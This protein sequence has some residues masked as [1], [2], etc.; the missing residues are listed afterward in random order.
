MSC[1][2][3][4]QRMTSAGRV[5][6]RKR[7][8]RA[9][10][11]WLAVFLVFMLL[12]AETGAQQWQLLGTLS[13]K[14]EYSDNL[15]FDDKSPVD[16]FI[17]T[18]TPGLQIRRN[19]ERL[20]LGLVARMERL[21]Y[22]SE[23]DM[24]ATEQ[25][26]EGSF[27]LAL[28][29]RLSLTGR[30]GYEKNSRPDRDLETTGLVVRTTKSERYS[31]D[32]S[33]NYRISDAMTGT[34]SYSYINTRYEGEENGDTESHGLNFAL[35]RDLGFFL[36]MSQGR[37]SL[38]YNRN[39]YKDATDDNYQLRVGFNQNFSETWSLSLDV[40]GSYT[41]SRFDVREIRYTPDPVWVR[42][43]EETSDW[44]AIGKAALSWKGESSG[45]TFFL[46]RDVSPAGDRGTSTTRTAV[47]W[48]M[49]GQFTADLS[50][51]LSGRYF[52]NEADPKQYSQA[53]IDE[54]SYSVNVGVRYV[55][56]DDFGVEASYS[57]TKIQDNVDE[58]DAERNL[59][60][61]RFYVQH[62]FLE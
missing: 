23:G 7:R 31:Y 9:A 30:A 35:S 13:V 46:S 18:V 53:E 25:Y 48:S 12:P 21:T 24:D 4:P 36:P 52:L 22:M 47:G 43:E 10:M 61:V 29:P 60:M 38:G 50:G 20:Q 62:A 40:G 5:R 34:L 58:T 57:Y 8:F 56:T 19:T 17:T 32:L 42:R 2:K 1:R 28:T 6:I 26:Y 16:D 55:L 39:I 54:E 41:R 59:F 37:V 11:F 45:V 14:E 33:G 51:S 49:T 44:G 27:G 3:F 15:F